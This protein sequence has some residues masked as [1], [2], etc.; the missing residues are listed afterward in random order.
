M[1]HQGVWTCILFAAAM[2]CNGQDDQQTVL[3]QPCGEEGQ[4]AECESGT[5][6]GAGECGSPLGS[7]E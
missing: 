6:A 4:A 1:N 7:C 3:E 5:C 2:G